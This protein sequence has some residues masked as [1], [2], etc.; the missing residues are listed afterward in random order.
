[1]IEVLL[2]KTIYPKPGKKSAAVIK[3]DSEIMSPCLTREYPLVYKRAEG[4]YAW[5]ADGKK[6]LDFAAFVAVM[7]VGNGNPDVKK[8]IQRQLKD[9]LHCGFADF[10]AEV[11]VRFVE[12][13]LTFLP[14]ELNC[15]FLSNSGTEAVE[16]AYKLAR[17]HTKR[18]WTIS[19]KGAFHGRTMG[20]L[21][22]TNAR[23]VQRE[24]Y[25]PFLPVSHVPYPYWYRMK[26]EPEECT[27]YCLNRLDKEMGRLNDN[28]AAVFIESVQG[29]NGYVVP[30]KNFI[31]GVR[32]LCNSHEVLLCDDEVQAGCFR[33]G[34]FLAIENFG[35]KPDIVSLSK[36][37]GGGMPLGATVAN[38]KIMDWPPGSHANT[39]GGNLLSCAAGIASLNFMRKKKLGE[40]A[41]L[42]GKLMMNRLAEMEEKYECIGNVRGIGL[43]IG[44]EIVK[45]KRT[46]ELDEK[47]RSAIVDDAFGKGLL[48]LPAG[49]SA[50]RICPPLIINKEQAENGLDILEDAIKAVTK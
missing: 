39:F 29:E 37:M 50:I 10:Y 43:M 30:P 40:N 22:M 11:P 24:R 20:S 47:T 17:W 27:D 23:P 16:A 6:Y 5:D 12:T 44:I 33:T 21:S 8:A 49:E 4:M 9:G 3:R 45:S 1:M 35:V 18:K 41:T 19:F 2:M 13:L 25:A 42:I 36:A 7:N 46:R 38:R 26:M 15:A 48:L 31:P 14:K 28:L 34:K 32:K